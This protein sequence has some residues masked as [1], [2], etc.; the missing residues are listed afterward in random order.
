MNLN[1]YLDNKFD[2]ARSLAKKLGVTDSFISQWRTGYRP[3]PVEYCAQIE[4]A[5]NGLVTRQHL[6]PLDWF[7]IWP[8]LVPAARATRKVTG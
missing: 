3:V 4:K 7:R 6:R 1:E 5:T 8:E 2:T